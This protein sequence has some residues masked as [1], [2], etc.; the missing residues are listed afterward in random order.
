MHGKTPR[1]EFRLFR[2]MKKGRPS[3]STEPGKSFK[4]CSLRPGLIPYAAHGL[5]SL[6]GM[7]FTRDKFSFSSVRRHSNPL[8]DPCPSVLVTRDQLF[9]PATRNRTAAP[10]CFPL[11][12][13]YSARIFAPP[14]SPGSWW[15][16]RPSGER[17]EGG[18][19]GVESAVRLISGSSALISCSLSFDV[20]L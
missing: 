2:G 12:L 5:P 4:I 19:G 10:R 15:K 8:S 16:L 17:S 11:F 9:G 14:F 18:R 20:C 7:Q 6:T 3:L 1:S 13:H